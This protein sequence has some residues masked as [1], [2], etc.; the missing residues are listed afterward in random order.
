VRNIYNTS[1]SYL[2]LFSPLFLVLLHRIARREEGRG[3]GYCRY[4]LYNVWTGSGVEAT[5]R[6]K[7]GS[8]ENSL[9]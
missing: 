6:T 7:T 5:V 9:L 4:R 2:A 8:V 3:E 1:H